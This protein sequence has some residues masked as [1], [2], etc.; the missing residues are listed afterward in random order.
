MLAAA[1]ID[2]TP[3]LFRDLRAKT[4]KEALAE[5]Q[6]SKAMR[7]MTDLAGNGVRDMQR[8]ANLADGQLW[9]VQQVA[10]DVAESLDVSPAVALNGVTDLLKN[11]KAEWDKFLVNAGADSW[12]RDLAS[13]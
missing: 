11:H 6:K 9:P 2:K 10:L 1:V 3:Y 7:A 13:A 4:L 12:I 5:G 8:L